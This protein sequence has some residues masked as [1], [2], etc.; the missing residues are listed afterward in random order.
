MAVDGHRFLD[1]L[2]PSATSRV[3]G[4]GLSDVGLQSFTP[5][6]PNG[7]AIAAFVLAISS[8]VVG[9]VPFLCAFAAVAAV[10]ALVFG[11]SSLARTRREGDLKGRGFALTAVLLAP[12]GFAVAG[13]GI[14]LTVVVVREFDRYSNAGEYT[15]VTTQCGVDAGV[16]HFDGTISNNSTKVRSYHVVVEFLRPGTQNALYTSS[17]NVTDIGPG[18]SGDISVTEPVSQERVDCKVS[19]VTGPLPFAEN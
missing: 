5:T 18:A 12:L 8:V 15:V 2:F 9:W 6:R 10:L 17:T 3:R 19:S 7:K 16:A 4:R 11:F 14:W 13:F 1:P